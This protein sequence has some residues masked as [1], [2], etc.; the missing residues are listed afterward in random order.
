MNTHG[1]DVSIV[2]LANP[3]LD[4]LEP[5]EAVEA[6]FELNLDVQK[7]CETYDPSNEPP[8]NDGFEAQTK[9]RLFAFGSLP[10]V[11][12]I[13]KEKVLESIQQIQELSYLRGVVMGTKGI[14]KGLDDPEMEPIYEA[15]AAAGLVVFVHPHYGIDNAFG[16]LDNG[17]VL[18][19]ALGFPMETSI[20]SLLEIF[21]SKS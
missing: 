16:D 17:H 13:Q 7:Y 9:D 3:W 8:T 4:F 18:P 14:G 2:S 12:G 10:L 19:L 5:E 1:I 21:R 15:L 20:V 11:P 6:A